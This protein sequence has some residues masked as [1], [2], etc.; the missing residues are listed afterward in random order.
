MLAT[1]KRRD[2]DF[3]CYYFFRNAEPANN[4]Q[5]GGPDDEVAPNVAKEATEGGLVGE[6]AELPAGA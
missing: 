6:G 3:S 5:P 1:T 2:Y 4:L